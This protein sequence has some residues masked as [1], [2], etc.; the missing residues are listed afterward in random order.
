MPIA[1]DSSSVEG[2]SSN[3]AASTISGISL[4]QGRAGRMVWARW[5]R[6][7][8]R[9]LSEWPRGFPQARPVRAPPGPQLE[10]LEFS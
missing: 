8:R 1:D 4:K 10:P 3:D 6:G 9:N 7:W 5:V 2:V